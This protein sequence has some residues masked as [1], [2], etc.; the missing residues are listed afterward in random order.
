MAY[1]GGRGGGLKRFGSAGRRGWVGAGSSYDGGWGGRTGVTSGV[2]RVCDVERFDECTR[3]HD[4]MLG[5]RTGRLKAAAGGVGP[6]RRT[7]ALVVTG[8]GD[9]KTWTASTRVPRREADERS[10]PSGGVW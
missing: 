3:S 7:K 10:P 4:G 9:R 5:D 2:V 1:G 6:I 8:R